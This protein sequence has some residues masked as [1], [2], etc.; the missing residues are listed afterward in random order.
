M[1]KT[2]RQL[3]WF[4]KLVGA[5]GLGLRPGVS[6]TCGFLS[7]R[8]NGKKRLRV[9]QAWFKIRGRYWRCLSGGPK[10]SGFAGRAAGTS[11]LGLVGARGF[12]LRPGVFTDGRMI[13]ATFSS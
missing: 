8:L 11:K 10:K 6:P 2:R 9:E 4:K 12:G 1:K 5:R 3:K 13:N 7:R